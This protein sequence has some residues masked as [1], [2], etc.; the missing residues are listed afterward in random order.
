MKLASAAGFFFPLAAHA[1]VPVEQ[2]EAYIDPTDSPPTEYA[3]VNFNGS[4]SVTVLPGQLG[5]AFPNITFHLV[6]SSPDGDNTESSHAMSV[7]SLMYGSQSVA[8]GE[9]PQVYNDAYDDFFDNVVQTQDNPG[10]S[11]V[12]PGHFAGS[13]KIINSS[14]IADYGTTS[15]VP[16]DT[17]AI[18]RI[19]FMINRDDVTFV[20]G[21]ETTTD[22]DVETLV[23][24]A[25]NALSV[26]GDATFNPSGS[27]GKQHADLYMPG[28]PSFGAAKVSGYAT[29]LYSYAQGASE[30]AAE[31]GAAIRSILMAGASKVGYVSQT[32]NNLD[33]TTGAGEANYDNSVAILEAGQKSLLTVSSNTVTGTPATMQQGW[34]YG[35]IASGSKEVVLFQSANTIEGVT[36][37]LNWNVT[38]SSTA[39]TINTSSAIFPNLALNVYPVTYSGGH[40]TLGTAY[41]TAGLSSSTSGDNVQYLYSTSSLP[42]GSYAFVITGDPSLSTAAAFSYT[43]AGSFASQWNSSSGSSWGTASNWTNGIPNGQAAQ[44]NLLASPG[45]ASPGTI[46]LDGDRTVGQITF[47]NSNGYTIAQG[48]VPSGVSGSLTID[49]TGDSTGTANPLI[50]VLAGSQTIS[51]PVILANGVTINTALSTALTISSAITGS[52]GLTKSGTGTLTL[53]A[54]GTFQSITINAGTMKISSAGSILIATDGLTIAG[55]TNNWVG[56]LDLGSNDLDIPGGNLAT[57]TNQIAQGYAN[58]AWTG[59]GITSSAAAANTS[60]LTALGVILNGTIY[61]TATGSLGTFDGINPGA[62]DVLVKYT[63]YGDANLD[64]QVDGS[65]YSLIDNGYHNHLTGWIN[66]DF[67]YDGVVD[68]SDYTLIDNAYNMQGGSLSVDTSE[69]IA[70]STEQIATS[71]SVPEPASGGLLIASGIILAKRRRRR[72]GPR[73]HANLSAL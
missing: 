61:G 41:T 57:I 40:Y 31:H 6:G 4:S 24:S 5:N 48:T 9:V 42:A 1:V 10:N 18:G 38:V 69:L 66:G 68:G 29:A 52:G 36:A 2:I 73:D 11:S 72:L 60:H 45:L 30:T 35:T 22:G 54:A 3:P 55:S 39:D 43:L 7:G 67:N 15:T 46:T 65:D 16:A 20:A 58:G 26:S 62:T 49:D 25:Y 33:T 13:A 70:A 17:D 59:D 53:D 34:S 8:L 28:Q 32:T 51:A 37:S 12:M 47:N 19:D 71:S 14:Y 56:T 50:T 23:W 44:A 21:A 63:Y 64:G 27:P